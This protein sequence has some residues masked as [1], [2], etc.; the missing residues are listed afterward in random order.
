MSVSFSGLSGLNLW[1]VDLQKKEHLD[2]SPRENGQDARPNKTPALQ[3][4]RMHKSKIDA[5]LKRVIQ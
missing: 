5:A 4:L 3:L 1:V 2:G